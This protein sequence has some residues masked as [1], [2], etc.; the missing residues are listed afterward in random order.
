M[1]RGELMFEAEVG[2]EDSHEGFL[3]EA[4]L[5]FQGV[6]QG[7]LDCEGERRHGVTRG[8]QS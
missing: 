4:R 2:E 5:Y 1:E 7:V 6:V 8:S 3:N